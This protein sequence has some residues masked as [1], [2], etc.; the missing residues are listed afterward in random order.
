M[1]AAKGWS[2]REK[3]D[4]QDSATRMLLLD[5]AK[6]VLAERGY[7]HT[8]V[9]DITAAAD[10][11]RATF[12]VYF[13]SKQECFAVLARDVRDAF[14]AAQELHDID[15]DDPYAVAEATNAAYL[16]VYAANLSFMTVL[17]HQSLVDPEITALWEEIRAHPT[18][19]SARYIR[20]LVR[21]GVAEPAAPPEV[22][23]RS[24]GAIAAE[25]AAKLVAD[26]SRRDELVAQL[27]AMFLRLV[28]VHPIPNYGEHVDRC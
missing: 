21:A 23:A 1:T 28:G 24:S 22:V 8:T 3:K 18:R 26:P 9:A 27:T 4:R 2:T 7:A 10:V 11:G 15:P 12:Y 14:L 5:A 6:R 25:M 19:R 16:D 20:R 17:R 13:A